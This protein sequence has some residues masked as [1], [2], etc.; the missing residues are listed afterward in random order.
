VKH[1]SNSF[2]N[3]PFVKNLTIDPDVKD[4]DYTIYTNK[5]SGKLYLRA[6]LVIPYRIETFYN[7][8]YKQLKDIITDSSERNNIINSL[9]DWN[10]NDNS[11]LTNLHVRVEAYDEFG[12]IWPAQNKMSYYNNVTISNG[13][14]IYK[15]YE[16]ASNFYYLIHD[17]TDDSVINFKFTPMYDYGCGTLGR[18]I[19]LDK[20]E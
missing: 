3:V 20:S 17:S 16:D 2:V 7:A 12:N 19:S 15:Y 14:E 5:T 18:V 10:I 9:S 6:E 8:E 1:P 4:S 11:Y 13:G